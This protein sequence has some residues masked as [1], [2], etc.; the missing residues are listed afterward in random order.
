M[1]LGIVNWSTA[2]VLAL[3]KGQRLPDRLRK[4]EYQMQQVKDFIEEVG[5]RLELAGDAI[6]DEVKRLVEQIFEKSHNGCSEYS[7]PV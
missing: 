3:L 4:D 5:F 6:D 7:S 1:I 2:G